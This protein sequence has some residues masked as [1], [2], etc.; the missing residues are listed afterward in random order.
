MR[1]RSARVLGPY[2]EREDRWRLV[3][4]SSNGKRTARYFS[5]KR[6]AERA[7]SS[8]TKQLHC[9][10]ADCAANRAVSQKPQ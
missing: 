3:D 9:P 4:I 8:G 6:D 7:K 1:K 5:T 2:K 10:P